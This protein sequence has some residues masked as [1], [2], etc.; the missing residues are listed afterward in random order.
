MPESLLLRMLQV[1]WMEIT[2]MWWF[3]L[4]ACL[5]VG[6]IKGYKLDLKIRDA[7][8]RSGA[9][10]VVLAVGIGLVSPL[11]ACGILPVA[12]SLAMVGTP[13]APL[14]A[15]LVAS[16]V[17]GP[18]AFVLTWRGLGSDWAL[19][20]LGGATILGL[21]AGFIT[22]LLE[23]QGYLAGN[24][25]RLKPIYNPDGTLAPA[26]MI[27]AAAGI[28]VK[29]MIIVPRDSRLHF[30]LDRTLDAAQFTGKFL[31]LAIVLE[32]I[33][34]TLVPPSWILGLVGADNLGSV[35]IA[36]LIG[37]PMPVN[38]IPLIPILAG[39]LHRGMD[40]GAALTLLL[41]GPVSSIPATV[42]LYGMFRPRVVIVFLTVSLGVSILLGWL[43]QLLT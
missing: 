41:A 19:L 6:I 40:H 27:G 18:D 8:R 35:V 36:A 37:L 3:F 25:V 7:L 33:I 32:A 42:A 26:R 5:L 20:K 14:I 9:W 28:R 22:L 30:I 12:I 4:L 43:Y 21:S 11:C 31:L 29:N 34:V 2:K 38:Q 10:G 23:K 17:M 1:V 13:L 15:L 16:P 39:L 24:Q